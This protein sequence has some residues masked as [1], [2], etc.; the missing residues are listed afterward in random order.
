MSPL[1]SPPTSERHWF[2]AFVGQNAEKSSRDELQRLGYE[3]FVASQK[4]ERRWKNGT[5]K[6]V[7]AVKISTVVFVHVTET[8]RRH[9]VNFPFIKSFM[10]NR[11]ATPGKYGARP[12]AVIPDHEMET[13]MFML[14]RAESPVLF[15]P[16]IAKGDH[17]RIVRGSMTGLEGQIVEVSNSA[18]KCVGVNV[19]ILGCALVH[20]SPDDLEK[21]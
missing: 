13:L 10:V 6:I 4:E 1:P 5:K 8:E 16:T 11:A 3:A 15:S 20:I 2:V 17:V 21:I 7:D 18:T 12:I 14:Y 9:I 19:G